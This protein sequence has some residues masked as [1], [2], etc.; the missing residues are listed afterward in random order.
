M[1]KLFACVISPLRV[2]TACQSTLKMEFVPASFHVLFCF[3]FALFLSFFLFFFVLFDWILR[4]D[5]GWSM[6][7]WVC[8]EKCSRPAVS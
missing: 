2:V 6:C 7:C 4:M 8:D 1:L 5:V 3:F